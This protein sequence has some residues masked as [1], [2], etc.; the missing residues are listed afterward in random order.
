[1][2]SMRR[3]GSGAGPSVPSNDDRR[4]RI[5]SNALTSRPATI[6]QLRASGWESIPVKDELRRNAMRKIADGEQLFPGVM[7]YEDTVCRSWRTRSSPA[8]T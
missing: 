3:D 6:G 1:V 2:G 5:A 8:T 7:G 4:M